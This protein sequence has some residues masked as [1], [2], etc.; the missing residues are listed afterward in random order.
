MIVTCDL[1]LHSRYSLATSPS[2]NLETLSEAARL[3]G[4]DL[5]AATDFTHPVWREE[6][7]SQLREVHAGSG[8]YTAFGSNFILVTEVSCVWRQD[9]KGR[10]IHVLIMAPDF[11]A[12][13]RMSAK[14]A[15]LQRLESDGR[16]IF[17]ISP[18]NV[19]EI[20][21]DADPR[22]ELIPAHVFTPWYGVFG[23][24]SG[25]D[26]L[27][28]CFGDLADEIFAVETG[29]S[30]DPAMHW[31]VPDSAKRSIVSCSD[32][33]SARTIG[34]ELTNLEIDELSYDAIIQALRHRRVASTYEFHPEHGKYHLDG[35]R[36]CDIRFSPRESSSHGDL[37][38]KCGRPLTLG[39]LNRAI[40]LSS[41][42]TR[43]PLKSSDGEFVDPLGKHPPFRHLI[44]LQEL[45]A[46][47]LGFGPN[48][49]T[50]A[51]AHLQLT[52]YCGNEID[53]LLSSTLED[54]RTATNS[55][56]IAM[57]IL[58]ARKGD[59]TVDPGYDGVYGNATPNSPVA[60][61][62]RV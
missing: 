24:K 30:S 8:I 36:K 3:K 50:V 51:R 55:D 49:K 25:F 1:H 21:R 43:S 60:S 33:H 10:R 32:A 4:I 34:R 5:L 42:E 20:A 59:V 40:K 56:E 22:C 54:I 18:R 61:K 2:L 29:L 6:M 26:S 46:H 9:E 13:D 14:F 37:C 31:T 28:E 57:A 12:V 7:R 62:T 27:E 53:A 19:L 41:T 45:I 23:A 15:K 17:K 35:H 44:P 47:A 11:D 16:P 58:A 39:V 52:A 38:P 48:T